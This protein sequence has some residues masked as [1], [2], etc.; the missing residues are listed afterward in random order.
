MPLKS[1]E[2]FVSKD[3]AQADKTVGENSKPTQSK[4]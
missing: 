2:Q 1:P 4:C 3:D